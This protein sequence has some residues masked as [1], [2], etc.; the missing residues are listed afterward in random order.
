MKH[1]HKQTKWN[2]VKQPISKTLSSKRLE[3]R[4]HD[5]YFGE[6]GIKGVVKIKWILGHKLT[7]TVISL[8]TSLI[9]NFPCK[10]CGVVT[11]QIP[12][13]V[14]STS[15]LVPVFLYILF[16]FSL[17]L[18]FYFDVLLW[19]SSSVTP[20]QRSWLLFNSCLNIVLV[21]DT[22]R[23]FVGRFS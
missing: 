12:P 6:K 10:S 7:Q 23:R 17:L 15:A 4:F 21:A 16:L 22:I 14:Y 11:R 19:V 1:A 9:I 2:S 20:Q 5:F 3:E 18:F 8:N 13:L